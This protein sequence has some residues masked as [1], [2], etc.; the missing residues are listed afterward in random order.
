MLLLLF[1]YCNAYG[2]ISVIFALEFLYLTVYMQVS[3]KTA[4]A[5]VF[6]L[7]NPDLVVSRFVVTRLS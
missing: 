7:S 6:C 4:I 2:C 1:F 5:I 3:R